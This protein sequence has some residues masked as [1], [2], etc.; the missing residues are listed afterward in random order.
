MDL[1]KHDISVTRDFIHGCK[2]RCWL[3]NGRPA[4]KSEEDASLF[5]A[6]CFILDMLSIAARSLKSST[7]K[8]A[9]RS[10]TAIRTKVTLPD[11]PY[12]YDV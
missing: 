7:V 10:L 12:D 9:I 3:V 11:L 6:F 2:W 4:Q 8:P 1:L 5:P